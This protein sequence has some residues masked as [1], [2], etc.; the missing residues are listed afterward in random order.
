MALLLNTFQYVPVPV[1][2]AVGRE[3]AASTNAST[4]TEVGTGVDLELKGGIYVVGASATI[5]PVAGTF[6]TV[7][8]TA[9]AD[10]VA[11]V[12]F[13]Q[14][15]GGRIGGL[16]MLV[17]SGTETRRFV[18]RAATDGTGATVDL[19]DLHFV[20]MAIGGPSV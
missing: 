1:L 16:F 8:F 3:D 11:Q 9:G 10:L 20:V 13:P 19:T 18:W 12:T 6:A 4:L 15:S 5:A 14:G 17:L 7:Q 2:S